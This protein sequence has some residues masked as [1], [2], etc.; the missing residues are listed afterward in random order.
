MRERCVAD[1]KRV[2]WI[3]GT[4]RR[5]RLFRGKK[6]SGW[7]FAGTSPLIVLPKSC[8]QSPPTGMYVRATYTERER[9]KR[10]RGLC[11]LRERERESTYTENPARAGVDPVLL[12]YPSRTQSSRRPVALAHRHALLPRPVASSSGST[13]TPMPIP[14]LQSVERLLAEAQVEVQTAAMEDWRS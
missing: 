2:S 6:N 3:I 8:Q 5:G 1:C 14:A 11:S 10:E 9:E 7:T 12:P 4:E 13:P